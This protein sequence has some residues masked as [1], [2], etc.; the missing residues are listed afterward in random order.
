MGKFKDY[1]GSLFGQYRGNL[2]KIITDSTDRLFELVR[3]NNLEVSSSKDIK[4]GKFYLIKYLYGGNPIWCPIFVI[5]DRFNTKTQKRIL[6]SI[7][8]EY[9][10]YQFKILYFDILFDGHK[11]IIEYNKEQNDQNR[12]V[13]YEKSFNVDFEIIQKSLKQ[14]GYD[15]AITAYNYM[16]IDGM[17]GG[18]PKMYGISTNFASRLM[19]VDTKKVNIKSMKDMSIIVESYDIKN[20]LD[21]IVR[22]LENIKED[23]DQ[24]DQK[25]Y[26][27]KLKLMEDKYKL[28]SEP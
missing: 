25:Q 17:D 16:K 21:D 9:L 4:K 8:L 6:Y 23:L 11:S 19:F 13:N 15:Y 20:K 18:K 22:I 24:D 1:C 5:D 3:K 2:V 27:K 14:Y 7:N 12:D 28:F 26:F 10:P